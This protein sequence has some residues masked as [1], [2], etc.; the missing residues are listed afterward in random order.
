MPLPTA[1]LSSRDDNATFSNVGTIDAATSFAF[2]QEPET[3]LRRKR[4]H[5]LISDLLDCQ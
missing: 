5:P 3:D 2:A 4:V 1:A